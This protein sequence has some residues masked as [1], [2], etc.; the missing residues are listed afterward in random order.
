[1]Y[2]FQ[3]KRHQELQQYIKQETKKEEGA[4][5]AV[6]LSLLSRSCYEQG[7][8]IRAVEYSTHSLVIFNTLGDSS[9]MRKHEYEALQAVRAISKLR[10]NKAKT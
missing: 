9:L 8:Y 4:S 1:V 3:Q 6:L 10:K 5:K 7:D 2:L